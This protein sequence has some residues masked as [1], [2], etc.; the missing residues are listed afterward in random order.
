MA[1]ERRPDPG[2]RRNRRTAQPK[3]RPNAPEIIHTQP[4]TFDRRRL[5]LRICTIVAVVLAFSVGLSIFFRVDE[6][7]VTGCNKYTAWTISE[8]SGME[9][10]DSLLFFG[11]ATVSSRIMDALPYVKSVRFSI[12]LPGSVNIIVEEAPV[13]YALQASDG[14]WWMMTSDGMIAEQTDAL[15]A[16]QTTTIIGVVLRDP[17]VGEQAEAYEQSE[18]TATTGADHLKAALRLA[19][20][21]ESNEILGK[22]SCLDVTNLQQLQMWHENQY[23]ILLGDQ[24]ELDTKIATIKAAIPKVGTYQTG[25]MELVKDGEVWKVVFTNQS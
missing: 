23:R 18:Q 17:K 12:K 8:A 19:Q 15:S 3:P 20:L 21:L 11:E 2:Q 9:K 4:K 25:T 5:L 6:I 1:T 16:Q 13:A 10:G 22:M 7:T 24:Q 14:S